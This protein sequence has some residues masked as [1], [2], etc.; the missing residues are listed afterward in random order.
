MCLI[1]RS[2]YTKE[3]TAVE[4]DNSISR[5]LKSISDRMRQVGDATFAEYGL[6]GPQVGYL[7]YIRRSGGSISQ[8]GLE[9][10]AGVSH[11]TIV[12]VVSRL[13]EKGYV[14]VQTDKKDRRNRIVFLTEKAVSVNESLRENYEE[15][16]AQ[17]LTGLSLE[18]KRELLR[19][20]A[21]IDSNI[22]RQA[23]QQKK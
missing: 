16:N 10:A 8:R 7:S 5:K 22:G 2:R 18:E 14:T 23:E 12:G 4:E 1:Q 15:M 11:P 17:L 9:K 20:L 3:V 6:T 21:V 13:Q 19:L